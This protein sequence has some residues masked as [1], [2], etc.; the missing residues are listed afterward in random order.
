MDKLVQVAELLITFASSIYITIVIVRFLLQWVRADFYNPLSQFIVKA[1]NPLLLPIRKVVPGFFGIDFASIVLALILQMASIALLIAI[2][3]GALPPIVPLLTFSAYELISL[4]LNIY[5]FAFIVLVIVSW[6][7]PN[8][9]N[10][11]V[12]L[13]NSITE[14]VLRPIRKILPASGGLDFSIMVALLIIY[15]LKIL[16]A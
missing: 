4:V 14:P 9:Q 11:A 10:P 5:F 15:I 8:G 16:I 7:A 2:K 6:V 12:A 13:L 3:S 1:T